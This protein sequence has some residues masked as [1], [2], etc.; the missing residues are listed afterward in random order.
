MCICSKHNLVYTHFVDGTYIFSYICDK[1]PGRSAG[2]RGAYS[3]KIPGVTG[4]PRSRVQPKARVQLLWLLCQYFFI[5]SNKFSYLTAVM[6]RFEYHIRRGWGWL[7]DS[8]WTLRGPET[9]TMGAREC[10]GGRRAGSSSEWLCG[11]GDSFLNLSEP[12]SSSI[13]RHTI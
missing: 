3:S 5:T 12:V 6:N 10:F 13:N 8:L 7:P 1:C 11:S 2:I 4:L 9:A